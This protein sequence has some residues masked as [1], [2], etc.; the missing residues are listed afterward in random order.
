MTRDLPTEAMTGDATVALASSAREPVAHSFR[1]SKIG[2]QHRER[3]AIVY[4]RQS[5]P[6]QVIENQESA[7]AT[8]RPGRPRQGAGLVATARVGD[9]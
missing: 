5:T 8:V 2:V 9:R 4:V 1:T 3:M 7:P 6:Q